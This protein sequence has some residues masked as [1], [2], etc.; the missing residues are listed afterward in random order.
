MRYIVVLLVAL[1]LAG[2]KHYGTDPSAEVQKF[3]GSSHQL[4]KMFCNTEVQTE[5][6][7]GDISG[8]WFLF[9]GGM[10]GHYTGEKRHIVTN[11]RFA[12]EIQDSTYTITTL[13]L[14]RVRVKLDENAKAPTVAFK[15]NGNAITDAYLSSSDSGSCTEVVYTKFRR[16]VTDYYNP[17]KVFNKYLEYVVITVRPEDWPTNITLPVQ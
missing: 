17:H 7:K 3:Y 11:I 4:R 8:G 12:W 5:P 15:V 16:E 14:N 9:M 10:E 2:C 13:P 1:S 6:A